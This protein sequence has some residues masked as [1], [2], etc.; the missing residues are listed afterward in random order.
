MGYAWGM[1]PTIQPTEYTTDSS[2]VESLGHLYQGVRDLSGA[3]ILGD[4]TL[5]L[6]LDIPTLLR[7]VRQAA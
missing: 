3:T 6:I 5:A 7:G 2:N 4:G 1:A